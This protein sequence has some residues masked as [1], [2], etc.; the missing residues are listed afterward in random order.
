MSD[1]GGRLRGEILLHQPFT[2]RLYQ[3]SV[4][5]LRRQAPHKCL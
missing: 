2:L 5:N 3:R 1:P 4:E